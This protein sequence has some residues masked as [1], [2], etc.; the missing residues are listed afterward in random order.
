[1]IYRIAVTGLNA[2]DDPNPGVAVIRSLRAAPE[3]QDSLRIIGLAYDAMDTG[4]YSEG[5]LDEVYMLPYAYQGEGALLH[6]LREIRQKTKIDV[7]IPTLDGELLNVIRSE[8][9]LNNMGIH[10]LLPSESSFKMHYKN[11]LAD[12]CNSN[13]IPA[14][15]TQV[16]YDYKQLEAAGRALGYPFVIKGILH[17]AHTA[18]SLLQAEAYFDLIKNRWGIPLIAQQYLSGEGRGVAALCDRKSK[19]IGAVA[20]RKLVVTEAGKGWAGVTV[21]DKEIM[22]LS[23]KILEALKWEGPL[24]LEFVREDKTGKLYL[25]EINPRFPAWIYLTA[26]A[27]QNLVKS[28]VELALGKSVK[29]HTSYKEGVVF[30]RHAVDEICDLERLAQI[31]DKGE[32]IF[33]HNRRDTSEWSKNETTKT[34]T[35][36]QQLLNTP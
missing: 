14:P 18:H 34:S 33:K 36:S 8:S 27:G 23:M 29:P 17:E 3:W 1:M 16:I 15:R 24:E 32:L 19:V 12:F 26:K 10:V 31:V 28:A 35:K 21:A 7:L 4:I 20:M 22:A 13:G 6:R 30:I 25:L 9:V 2:T 11:A 5:L